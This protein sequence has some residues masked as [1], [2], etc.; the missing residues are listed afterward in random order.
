M[1]AGAGSYNTS[2]QDDTLFFGASLKIKF[3][4]TIQHV[5]QKVCDDFFFFYTNKYLLSVS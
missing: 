2:A 4:V 1:E 3:L 5:K